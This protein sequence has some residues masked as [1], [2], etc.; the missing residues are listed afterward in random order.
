MSLCS[1]LNSFFPTL[2]SVSKEKSP[3]VS[4]LTS[5]PLSFKGLSGLL[6]PVKVILDSFV[7]LVLPLKFLS[8][9][10]FSSSSRVCSAIYLRIAEANE[11]S[12]KKS[13]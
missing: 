2:S 5:F 8:S 12:D 13:S 9:K 1:K 11:L 3:L 6:E 7:V 4:R 10:S